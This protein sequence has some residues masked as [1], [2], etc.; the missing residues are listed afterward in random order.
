MSCIRT[1][2]GFAAGIFA[3]AVMGAAARADTPLR[4][5]VVSR[6]IFYLPAWTAQAQGFFRQQGVD[7]A[8]EVYDGSDKISDDLRSGKLQIGVVP[9]EGLIAE[10]YKGGNL[11]AVAGN[12]QRL[13]LQGQAHRRRRTQRDDQRET[14]MGLGP[15]G[16][17][18]DERQ[19]AESL[20][21]ALVQR[22]IRLGGTC[23]G[24]HGIGLHKMDFLIQETAVS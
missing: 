5:G 21:Q 16:C 10:V 19:R 2:L 23:T 15:E 1:V 13:P 20:N 7:V 6:T 9:L 11:R 18:H 14:Y 24:E 17:Q 22:A 8:I 3:L 4:V 12:A